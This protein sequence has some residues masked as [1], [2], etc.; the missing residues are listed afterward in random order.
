MQLIAVSFFF[1]FNYAQTADDEKTSSFSHTHSFYRHIQTINQVFKQYINIQS[2]YC[3]ENKYPGANQAPK[4]QI[5]IL[6]NA[7]TTLQ[8]FTVQ[9]L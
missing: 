6:K 5:N 3:S 7:E 1:F 9:R 4:Q 2:D 8:T